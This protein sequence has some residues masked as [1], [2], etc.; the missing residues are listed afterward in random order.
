M[1]WGHLPRLDKIL[2]VVRELPNGSHRGAGRTTHK[3]NWTKP[4]GHGGSPLE[5]LKSAT[6]GRID[7]V[8]LLD[9]VG[10][11][12]AGEHDRV[13][14]FFSH[15]WHAPPRLPAEGPAAWERTG[16]VPT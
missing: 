14:P 8:G 15:Q 1:S 10:E 3:M 7:A 11:R 12:S 5:D 16:S 6:E 9:A 13:S 4:L 2:C